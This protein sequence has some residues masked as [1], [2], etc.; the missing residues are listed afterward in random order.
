MILPA[1]VQN[2]QEAVSKPSDRLLQRVLLVYMIR[3]SFDRQQKNDNKLKGDN[4]VSY[5]W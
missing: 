2:K 4:Y 5:R 1:R 3:K